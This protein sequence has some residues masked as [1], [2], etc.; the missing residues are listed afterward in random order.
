MLLVSIS[1]CKDVLEPLPNDGTTPNPIIDPVVQNLPGSALISYTLPDDV[2]LLYV[3]AEYEYKGVKMNVK[4]SYYKNTILIE[5]FADTLT[6]AVILYAVSR[7]EKASIPVTVQIKPLTAPIQDVYTSLLV[8]ESFGGFITKFNNPAQANVVIN[9]LRYDTIK[10]E[11]SPL[12]AYYSNAA[13]GEFATRGL[14]SLEQQFGFFAKDRWNNKTDTLKLMIKPVY[15]MQLDGTKFVD[16]RKRYP[17]PQMPPLPPSG[18]G[19]REP[20]DY[21]TSL[22]FKNMFDASVTSLFHTKQGIDQPMWI[23]IDL[24]AK[25]ILSRYKLYQRTGI[26]L[27]SHGNP[28]EW[29]IWGTNT[30]NDPLSWVKLT[31]EIMIKPSGLPIGGVDNNDIALGVSGQEFMFPE[32][33]PAVQYIAWKSIDAWGSVESAMGMFHLGALYFWGQAVK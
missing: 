22:V 19:L 18:A 10:K 13:S 26:Y 21:S 2:S 17:I 1:S 32:D 27:F 7:G 28:H 24:S 11:W 30:P 29:E 8:K 16:M 4:S 9:V 25:Y 14:D 3:K 33:M 20:L 31:H 5:G 23:P 12:D 15:E 6:H